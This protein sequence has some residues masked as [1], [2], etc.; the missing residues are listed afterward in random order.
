MLGQISNLNQWGAECSESIPLVS[1]GAFYMT[2]S[3]GRGGIAQEP[4]VC[5]PFVSQFAKMNMFVNLLF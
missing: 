5:G 4:V 3:G 2:L 1:C